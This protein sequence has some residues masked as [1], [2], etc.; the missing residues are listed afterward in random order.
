MPKLLCKHRKTY[1]SRGTGTERQHFSPP[2]AEKC[3]SMWKGWERSPPRNPAQDPPS[4]RL[5]HPP[6][7]PLKFPSA[8]STGFRVKETG[9]LSSNIV[10][11][12]HSHEEPKKQGERR[13]K[14]SCMEWDSLPAL[15]RHFMSRFPVGLQKMKPQKLRGN[16]KE[17]TGVLSIIQVQLFLD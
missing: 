13:E 4:L 2:L 16:F 1:W 14:L 10:W 17:H 5:S 3:F 12:L 15:H 11:G 9:S 7:P 6:P 8:A